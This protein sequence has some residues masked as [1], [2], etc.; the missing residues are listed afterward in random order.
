MWDIQHNG[1]VIMPSVVV[2]NVVMMSVVAP[3]KITQALSMC[4]SMALP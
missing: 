3:F 1:S 2:M 4:I